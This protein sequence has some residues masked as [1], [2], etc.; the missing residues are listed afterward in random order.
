MGPFR[1]VPTSPETLWFGVFYYIFAWFFKIRNLKLGTRPKGGSPQ[2]KS[3]MKG[4]GYHESR[5]DQGKEPD[6]C[7]EKGLGLLLL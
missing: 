7:E 3:T 1:F 6:R 5:K 4:G 2:D